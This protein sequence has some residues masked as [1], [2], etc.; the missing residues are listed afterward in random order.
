MGDPPRRAR[1]HEEAR[2]AARAAAPLPRP[3]DP[4]VRRAR[5]GHGGVAR[6]PVPRR[7][8]DRRRH[9]GRRRGL[10]HPDPRAVHRRGGHQLGRH[11]P[12]DLPG[13]LG[14]PARAGR[15]ALAHLQPPPVAVD[16]LLLAQQGGRADLA[17]HQRRAG[18]R[19][20]GHRRHRHPVLRLAHADRH[21]GILLFMDTRARAGHLRGL[22]GPA[23]R[24]H[25]LP[26]RV[27][28]GL[29]ADPGE[30]RVRHRVPA[31]DPVRAS[32]SCARSARSRATRR[33]SPS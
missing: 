21:G 11:L 20:A 14:R 27:G 4:D 19:P 7:P 10:P 30:D 13:Q 23:D 12:P 31:G 18:A 24:Q 25:R 5:R 1:A 22:P 28:R 17:A 26:D 8:R 3:G 32:G 16:R 15:P 6:S 33:A 2:Q 9:Q 29:P